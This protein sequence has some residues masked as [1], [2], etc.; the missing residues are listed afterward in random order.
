LVRNLIYGVLF[1]VCSVCFRQI[2]DG[3]LSDDSEIGVES[4]DAYRSSFYED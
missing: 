4:K 1:L 3:V 2:K